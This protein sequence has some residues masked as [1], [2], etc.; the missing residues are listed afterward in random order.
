MKV[1]CLF[2]YEV[3]D[4]RGLVGVYDTNHKALVG[5]AE[6]TAEKIPN[7]LPRDWLEIHK[8][9]WGTYEIE[10]WEVNDV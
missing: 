6:H 5:R 4:S 3:D 1:Y 10:E 7:P 8:K 9:E 2:R